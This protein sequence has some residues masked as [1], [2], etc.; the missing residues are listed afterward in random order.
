MVVGEKRRAYHVDE[1]CFADLGFA[2]D[3]D[4]I[5]HGG[6]AGEGMR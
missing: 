5:G 3:D 1:A 2:E 4:F 6:G